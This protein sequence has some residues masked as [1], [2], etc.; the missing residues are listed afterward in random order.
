MPRT[1]GRGRLEAMLG[2]H[3]PTDA[4]LERAFPG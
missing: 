1:P 3:T 2:I 4:D